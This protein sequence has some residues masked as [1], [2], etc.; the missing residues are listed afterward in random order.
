[1]LDRLDSSLF[2]WS[3]WRAR[4]VS[5]L[6]DGYKLRTYNL[7]FIR[8]RIKRFA[9]G[10]CFGENLNCRPKEDSVALMCFLNGEHFW[11]H[12]RNDEFYEIFKE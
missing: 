5:D 6:L 8:N 4:Q 1:M 7:Q 3:L 10:Y 12:L 2:D 11:F 9:V